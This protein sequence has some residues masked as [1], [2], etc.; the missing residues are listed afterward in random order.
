MRNLEKLE[1]L[2]M[3]LEKLKLSYNDIMFAYRE[4]QNE[5]SISRK[6]YQQLAEL[7][8]ELLKRLLETNQRKQRLENQFA[9]LPDKSTE[10]SKNLRYYKLYEQFYLSLMQSKSEFE[11]TQAGSIP[12]FKIL[13]PATMPGQPPLP[14]PRYDC[15]RWL[16]VESRLD[17]ILLGLLYLVNNK[18]TSITEIEKIDTVPVLGVIPASNHV[19]DQGLHVIEHPKSVVSQAIRILRTNWISSAFTHQTRS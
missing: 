3:A 11:I 10:F 9:N 1:D 18:I 12:D 15:R 19:A 17:V 13:S 16:C 14:Q 4:K 7:K 8:S 5:S 2:T 6:T